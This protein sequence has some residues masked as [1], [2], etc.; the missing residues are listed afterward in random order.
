MTAEAETLAVVAPDADIG[1]LSNCSLSL[2]L[3][4]EMISERKA[5]LKLVALVCSSPL[6][7]K[8]RL[9]VLGVV[10]LLMVHSS[11]AFS[12]KETLR[13]LQLD[14]DEI[15][16]LN[17]GAS[18]NRIPGDQQ[19]TTPSPAAVALPPNSN[20]TSTTPDDEF[21]WPAVEQT[22]DGYLNRSAPPPSPRPSGDIADVT[23]GVDEGDDDDE[24]VR[25]VSR[26]RRRQAVRFPGALATYAN[27]YANS[28][29]GARMAYMAR[30]GRRFIR[31]P[32]TEDEATGRQLFQRPPHQP[33]PP[34]PPSFVTAPSGEYGTY[35]PRASRIT[36]GGSRLTAG[37]GGEPLI[38]SCPIGG[39]FHTE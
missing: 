14:S 29:Y 21:S 30:R 24:P 7:M 33:P 17:G 13:Q 6:A 3:F 10:V 28:S 32:I 31:F 23:V 25:Y 39:D 15:L 16:A 37:G 19:K 18:L 20:R 12:D 9:L 22:Y 8:V 27:S 4:A 38:G 5:R 35:W 1:S 2:L 26:R 11:S 36:K 34:P